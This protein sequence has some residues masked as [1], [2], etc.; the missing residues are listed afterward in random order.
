MRDLTQILPSAAQ[1]DVLSTQSADFFD[2]AVYLM[3]LIEEM[4]VRTL[5]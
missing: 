1:S 4:P 3:V 5:E 2:E